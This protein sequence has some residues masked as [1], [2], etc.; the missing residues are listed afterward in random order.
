M[1]NKI[2]FLVV[3]VFNGLIA[4]TAKAVYLKY[5]WP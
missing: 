5:W 1:E 4:E 2:E 3:A